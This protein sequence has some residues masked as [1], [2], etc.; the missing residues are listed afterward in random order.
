[1]PAHVDE[2]YLHGH[3]QYV[4]INDSAARMTSCDC[5]VSQGSVLGPL[6]FVSYI[7]PVSHVIG[8]YRVH[9]HLYADDITLYLELG[10][11][12]GASRLV[13]LKCATA[14]GRSFMKKDKA[15]EL[16]VSNSEVL[17]ISITPN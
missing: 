9:Q 10:S 3:Q 12:P 13:V 11:D 14:A 4:K 2:S 17:N 6:L 7:A 1:M 15:K 8:T 5:S 16:N